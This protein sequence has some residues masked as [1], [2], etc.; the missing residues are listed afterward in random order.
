MEANRFVHRDLAARNVLLTRK[1]D[2]KIAKISDFGM[3]REVYESGMYKW[4]KGQR[5]PVKWWSP[6]SLEL[7]ECTTKGDV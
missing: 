2:R 4:Q 1:D 5:V 7:Y 6:E 3:G